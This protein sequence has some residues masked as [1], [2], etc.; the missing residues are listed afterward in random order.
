MH[1]VSLPGRA[2]AVPAIEGLAA[3]NPIS[4][5]IAALENLMASEQVF[6]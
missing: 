1:P 2:R 3:T 5:H 6:R 4:P